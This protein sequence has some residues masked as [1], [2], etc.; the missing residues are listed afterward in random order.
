MNT[1]SLIYN[2]CNY[3]YYNTIILNKIIHFNQSNIKY[4]FLKSFLTALDAKISFLYQSK[5]II[6]YFYN[7]TLFL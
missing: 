2:Y 5:D 4:E 7:I 1:C 6:F 3:K